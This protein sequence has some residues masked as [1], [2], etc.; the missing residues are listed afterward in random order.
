M[1][2]EVLKTFE[3]Y[4]AAL[5]AHEKAKSDPNL[6]VSTGTTLYQARRELD[7]LAQAY[8]PEPA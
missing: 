2:D 3:R 5:Q 8:V 7:Q 1:K 6:N 4:A